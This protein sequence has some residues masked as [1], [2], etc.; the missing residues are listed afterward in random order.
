MAEFD[1]TPFITPD[2]VARAAGATQRSGRFVLHALIHE[3]RA[4]P[5]KTVTGRWQLTPIEAR[6]FWEA[7]H[8]SV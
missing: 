7:L 4:S 6:V 3:G 5:V 8:G 1:Q 2:S